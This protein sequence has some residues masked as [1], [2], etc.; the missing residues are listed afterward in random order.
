MRLPYR[1]FIFT[2]FSNRTDAPKSGGMKHPVLVAC[3]LALGAC[4]Q[5]N[6]SEAAPPIVQPAP[7]DLSAR[8]V[9]SSEAEVKL[10]YAPV[11]A[12]SSPAVVNVYSQRVVT[13]RTVSTDP[14]F[15][16]FF[17]GR[18]GVPQQRVEQS[19]GSG[20]I[21]RSDGI[22]VTNNHVI[23]GATE[24][25]VVLADRREFT[26][27]L[28]LADA[29]ADLAVLKIDSGAEK[30]P[31]LPF[32]ADESA[33]VGDL[34][35]AIGNPF[36]V[37][38]TVTSGIVSALARSD[39]GI[40]DYSYFIQTDA[41]INPGNSGGAL[42]DMN[43]RLMGVNTAIFSRGGGSNGIGF[44]IPAAMVRRVVESAVGGAQT[45]VRPWFGIKGQVVT[46]DVA[47]AM[48]LD[49]PQ[50]VL[51]A[52]IY[53]NG[54]AAKAGLK[55]GDVVLRVDGQP[56]ND[57]AG[58]KYQAAIK[59]PGARS[60][61]DIVHA[62]GRQNVTLTAEVL[63]G[64]TEKP[65]ILTVKSPLMGAEVARLTPRSADEL[66]LDPFAAGVV[67]TGLSAQ[68]VAARAGFAPGDVIISVNGQ[69]IQQLDDLKDALK[70]SR[71]DIVMD[72]GGKQ[73]VARY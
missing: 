39:V 49:R 52:D 56:I 65:Q 71:W 53:P 69:P 5:P 17:G 64:G 51:V 70:A 37:G 55:R 11:V 54:P 16:M 3:L 2:P 19:L 15:N 33:A 61:F 68:S 24:L 21:L 23:E 12:K 26:A 57:D 30:L 18:M 28:L 36:G 46:A 44:A 25:K 66:G 60:V 40:T 9:P 47:R 29:K 1:L 45:V 41:A 32:A 8:R 73:I 13:T 38:Q 31:A 35:L 58:L 48:G 43:G 62:G 72:R 4:S 7:V 22:V 20:V 50:G 6:Q 14:F 67:I 63:P 34:V 42:V 59:R 27:K 10:S